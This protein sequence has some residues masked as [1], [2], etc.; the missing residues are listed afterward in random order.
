MPPFTY[1]GSINAILEATFISTAD[2]QRLFRYNA[3]V[4]YDEK[5]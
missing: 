1:A 5:F 2:K 3:E 4:L